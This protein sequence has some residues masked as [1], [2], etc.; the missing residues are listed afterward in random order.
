M[1]ADEEGTHVQLQGHMHSLVDPKIAQHSGRVVK[2]TGDGVLAEFGSVVDAVRCAVEIQHGMVSRNVDLPKDKRI[3]FR[4]GINVG[5][6]IIDR[7][8][9]FGDGVNVA[10]RLEGI[11]EPGGICVSSRVQEDVRGKVDICFEDAG[12]QQLKNIAQPVRVYFVRVAGSE[13]AFPRAAMPSLTSLNKPSIAVLPFDNLSDD[14]QQEYLADGIVEELITELSRMRWLSVIARDS[15]FALKGRPVDAK[16]LGRELGAHYLLKGGVRK[17]TGRVRI[18]AQLLDANT[19]L[20]L[21]ADRFEGDAGDLFQLQDQVARNVLGEI[22]PRL[23][24]AESERAK[25]KRTENLDAYDHYL[26]GMASVRLRTRQATDEAMGYFY[27][28]IALD[29]DFA[30]AWA[31]AAW[32]YSRRKARHWVVDR[33]H[34]IAET[35]R[36]AWQAVALGKDDADT[37]SMAGHAL[38]FV[39]GELD[40]GT[41]LIER[42]LALNPNM[43]ATWHFSGWAQVWLGKPDLAIAHL[44]RAMHLSPL[45]LFMDSMQAATADAHFFADRYGEAALWANRVL[46]EYPD[47]HM[48]LRIAIVSNALGG[49]M[50][51]AKKASNL[52]LQLDPSF[53]ICQLREVLGPLQPDA[54]G[55]YEEGLRKAG[56]PE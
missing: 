13:I 43:A 19:G 12:E 54:I 39:V 24:Q 9:I 49:S 33:T 32:C 8:D 35:S 11:A 16:R 38:N 45:D 52:L 36:L 10:V 1:G 6:V 50:D 14:P 51:A 28:A 26:R 25:R 30:L 5:D 21:W 41:H 56:L 23:K 17:A 55:K 4:I 20:Y 40:A 18:N 48:A 2:N 37:L 27:R 22:S 15:S 31:V 53:R 42:A 29:P 44:L 3:D 47:S 46:R 34:D 7:S